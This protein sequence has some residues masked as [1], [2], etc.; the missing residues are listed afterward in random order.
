[1]IRVDRTT[2]ND[3]QEARKREWLETNGL[4]GFAS[5]T[6]AGIN[7]RRYHGLLMAATQPPTGRMLL[8]SKLEETLVLEDR[9]FDLSANCYPGAVHPRGFEL[10]EEFRMDPFPTFVYRVENVEIEKRV[11]M[12]HGEN[13]TVIEF[14]LRSVD[15]DP[16][17]SSVLLELRPLVAFRDYHS[18]THRNDAA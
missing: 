16:V 15:G 10:L 6:V 14:E 9:R 1:M 11:F 2:C 18:T 5:S 7:T 12:V 13:T 17:P 4:G 8:L 3:L